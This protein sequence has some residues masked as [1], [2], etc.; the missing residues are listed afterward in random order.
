M[1]GGNHV[2]RE[3]RRLEQTTERAF[4]EYD[5]RNALLV[6]ALRRLVAMLEASEVSHYHAAGVLAATRPVLQPG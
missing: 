5:E 6:D 1:G 4:D 2:L 3:V